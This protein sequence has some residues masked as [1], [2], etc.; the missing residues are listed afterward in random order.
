[1]MRRSIDCWKTALVLSFVP[2]GNLAAQAADAVPY[3]PPWWHGPAW[4]AFWWLLPL[5]FV[6]VMAFMCFAMMRRGGRGAPWERGG[7]STEP[8]GTTD[9]DDSALR[10]LD[11]LREGRDRPAGIR[12][13]ESGHQ[14]L[15]RRLG[16]KG[17]AK[18]A[19]ALR[20]S[21]Y[22]AIRGNHHA[23]DPL[24]LRRQFVAQPARRRPGPGSSSATVSSS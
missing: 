23:P 8:G 21:T 18:A 24:P 2:V 16:L 7:R 13:E 17:E 10:I 9:A 19:A 6:L 14:R 5:A 12:R 15:G 1:M 22:H 11:A 3:G 4:P 20:R